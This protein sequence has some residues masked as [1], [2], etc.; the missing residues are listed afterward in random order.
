MTV[1]TTAPA[2]GS[3][4]AARPDYKVTFPRVVRSE[5]GKFLSL[6]STL[7]ALGLS[8]VLLVAVGL[9]AAAVYTPGVCL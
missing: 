1:T 7:I 6:R 9:I 2:T 8:Q 5:I 4:E 3:R